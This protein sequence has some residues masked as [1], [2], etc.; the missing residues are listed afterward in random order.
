VPWIG[1]AVKRRCI[2]STEEQFQSNG[3]LIA[4]YGAAKQEFV[5]LRGELRR[6]LDAALSL[7]DDIANRNPSEYKDIAIENQGL[8]DFK[9]LTK[10]LQRTSDVAAKLDGLRT[11]LEAL[12]VDV[13]V[14]FMGPLSPIPDR[15]SESRGKNAK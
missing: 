2:V 10:N 8:V 3:R 9:K 5:A 12:G 14:D 13:R 15:A 6:F 11:H 4:E 1:F 7:V